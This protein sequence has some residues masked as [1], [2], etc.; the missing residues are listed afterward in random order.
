MAIANSTKLRWDN[1]P[2]KLNDANLPQAHFALS[3][4]TPGRPELETEMLKHRGNHG[5]IAKHLHLRIGNNAPDSLIQFSSHIPK[6]GQQ[7]AQISQPSKS[8]GD[9]CARQTPRIHQVKSFLPKYKH[10]RKPRT[11]KSRKEPELTDVEIGVN[12]NSDLITENLEIIN[13]GLLAPTS[14]KF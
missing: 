6:D 9:Y 14:R 1:Y 11:I 10:K 13:Q 5:R 7:P 2:A 12:F 4:T 8:A 3:F